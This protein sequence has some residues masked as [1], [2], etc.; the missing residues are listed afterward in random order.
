MAYTTIDRPTDYFRTK[1]YS[2]TGSNAAITFDET[3]NS[4]QPDFLW[5]KCRGS[6]ES[7][8]RH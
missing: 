2:G 4:M 6:N 8:K 7:N 3:D 1:I 5:G